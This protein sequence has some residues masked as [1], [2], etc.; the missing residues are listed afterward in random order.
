MTP[1]AMYD[2]AIATV[3]KDDI[4]AFYPL[5]SSVAFP[6]FAGRRVWEIFLGHVLGVL[7]IRHTTFTDAAAA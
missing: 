5:F 7:N 1:T 3:W 4:I 2:R 6:F